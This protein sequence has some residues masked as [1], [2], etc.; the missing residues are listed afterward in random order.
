ML[1]AKSPKEIREVLRGAFPPDSILFF[2]FDD[3]IVQ[4]A[5]KIDQVI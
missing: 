2:D 3:D 4:G 5:G 1:R